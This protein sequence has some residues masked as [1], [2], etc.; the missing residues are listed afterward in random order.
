MTLKKS[1]LAAAIAAAVAMPVAPAFAA[2]VNISGRVHQRLEIAGLREKLELAKT[3]D[4]VKGTAITLILAG[5][6]S[7]SFMGFAGLA[8]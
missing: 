3:P 2:D 8:N 4:L 6:L 7:L 1:A 5:L